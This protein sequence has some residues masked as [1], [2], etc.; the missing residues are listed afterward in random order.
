[1]S[2]SMSKSLNLACFVFIVY[3]IICGILLLVDT[4]LYKKKLRSSDFHIP[5]SSIPV[6]TK[7]VHMVFSK[8]HLDIIKYDKGDL[9]ELH[10]DIQNKC[11]E[12]L[13]IISYYI[14]I[15]NS[16]IYKLDDYQIKV[17]ESKYNIKIRED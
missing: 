4:T 6:P 10:E 16:E 8:E 17:L 7:V 5:I 2:L 12:S 1:M 11:G 9:F 3:I 14:A 15:S 13:R